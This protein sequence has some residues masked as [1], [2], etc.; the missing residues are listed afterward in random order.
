MSE[1]DEKMTA[2]RKSTTQ[3]G[4]EPK[5]AYR[6]MSVDPKMGDI[7]EQF[8]LIESEYGY[9]SPASDPSMRKIRVGDSLP[10]GEVTGITSEG[11][12]VI[13]DYGDEYVIPL[14]GRPGYKP[15]TRKK[16]PPV[17][18]KSPLESVFD[19]ADKMDVDPKT[20]AMSMTTDYGPGEINTNIYKEHLPGH[21]EG[22]ALAAAARDAA[23]KQF[24]DEFAGQD[25]STQETVGI[26]SKEWDKVT[27]GGGEVFL[28]SPTGAQVLRGHNVKPTTLYNY[29]KTFDHYSPLDNL[30][31]HEHIKYR[32]IAE[33]LTDPEGS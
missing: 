13:P 27:Y 14:G 28:I 25:P 15:P 7:D 29:P 22:D 23:K 30:H 12:K 3:A 8:S 5:P 18:A 19:A 16:S 1:Y 17:Q 4:D 32:R 11:I 24:D 26:D 21:L 33:A 6:V 2:L 31:A 10:E 9:G 20:A